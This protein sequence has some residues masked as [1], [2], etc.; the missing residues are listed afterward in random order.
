MTDVYGGN[1]RLEKMVEGGKKSK[2]DEWRGA[3]GV[4]EG[5]GEQVGGCGSPS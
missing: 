1:G 2:I 5:E 4:R 3:R